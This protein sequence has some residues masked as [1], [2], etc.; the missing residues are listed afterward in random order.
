[1]QDLYPDL[2]IDINTLAVKIKKTAEQLKSLNK[3][4]AA[5]K[6][7]LAY[8][9]KLYEDSKKTAE[10]YAALKSDTVRAVEKV[11]RLIKKIDT[12]KV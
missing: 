10:H 5:L 4:N 9:K 6:A 7:D 2:D 1:M 3:E 11:E 8:Y 12:I